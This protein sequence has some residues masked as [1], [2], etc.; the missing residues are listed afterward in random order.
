MLQFF[1]LPKPVLLGRQDEGKG[2]TK[3]KKAISQKGPRS[4]E[5]RRKRNE[6]MRKKKKKKKKK[7]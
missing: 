1:P 4:V 5:K 3:R 2:R 6:M 7:A